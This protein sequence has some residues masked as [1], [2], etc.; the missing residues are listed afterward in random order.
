ML[1][2]GKNPL[3]RSM[4]NHI[5]KMKITDFML[6]VVVQALAENVALSCR[7]YHTARSKCLIIFIS[8]AIKQQQHVV[9]AKT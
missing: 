1:V 6:V 2:E 9:D 7:M 4:K 3:I 8:K 5:L